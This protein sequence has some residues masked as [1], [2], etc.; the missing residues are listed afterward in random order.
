MKHHSR[1]VKRAE[2]YHR[3]LGTELFDIANRLIDCTLEIDRRFPDCTAVAIQSLEAI[4]ALRSDLDNVVCA[5][6]IADAPAIYFPG[7]GCSS[8][9]FEGEPQYG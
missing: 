3:R 4:N 9:A 8:G 7:G 2:A 6:P 1:S 5:L